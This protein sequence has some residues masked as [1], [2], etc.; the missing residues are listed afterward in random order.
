VQLLRCG[1]KLLLVSVTPT[2][3]ETL[4]EITDPAEVERLAELCHQGR[5]QGATACFRRV[6]EQLTARRESH[7]THEQLFDERFGDAPPATTTVSAHRGE[8]GLG[9]V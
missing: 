5:A 7:E 6:F 3:A 4:T 9:H 2:T 8:R 1:G